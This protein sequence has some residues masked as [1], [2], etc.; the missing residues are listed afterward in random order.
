MA[1]KLWQV[2]NG[3]PYMVNP[4]LGI[5][6]VNPKQKGKRMARKWGKSH[7][8]WVRSFQSKRRRKRNYPVAGPVMALANRRGGRRR[9]H[10]PGRFRAAATRARGFLGL[11][12]LMPIVYGS[13]GFVATA[14]LQGVVGSF[15]PVEWS[16]NEDGSENKL[17]KYGLLVVSL[18]GTTWIAK[19]AF[20]PGPAALAGVGGGVYVVSQ[21]VKDFMPGVIPGMGQY[22]PIGAYRGLRSYRQVRGYG[23][24]P[25]GLAAPNFG[26][27]NTA[28]SAPAGAG[29][30][31]AARFR[32]FQ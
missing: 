29:N 23:D 30:L 28:N 19:A 15:V 7:M 14:G 20:G 6:G 10:N 18:I 27:R 17:T 5:L 25:K 9:K 11:P 4:H 3:E 21:V 31:V 22:V 12:P 16:V 2:F 24:P 32:R 1:K 8:A 13:A 26:A